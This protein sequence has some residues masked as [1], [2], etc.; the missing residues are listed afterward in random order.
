MRRVRTI[1]GQD[2]LSF[3]GSQTPE[4]GNRHLPAPER[5]LQRNEGKN[6]VGCSKCT[7]E[8]HKLRQS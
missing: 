3:F 6:A 4:A 2:H 8:H 7:Q 1:L 5:E